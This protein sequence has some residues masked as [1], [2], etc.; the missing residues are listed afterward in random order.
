AAAHARL[1]HRARDHGAP[2][3]EGREDLRGAGSLPGAELRGGQEADGDRRPPRALDAAA[4]SPHAGMRRA[5]WIVVSLISLGA[6]VWSASRQH[7]PRMPTDA[8]GASWLAASL[9][10]YAVALVLRGW[11]WHRI[12]VLARIPHKRIDAFLLTLVA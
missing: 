4:L 7:A 1:R 9:G 11:R 8:A 6:V 5:I 2:A 3:A 12:M 10:V